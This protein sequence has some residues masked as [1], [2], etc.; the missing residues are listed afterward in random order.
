MVFVFHVKSFPQKFSEPR[1]QP[2]GT[3]VKSA[4]SASAARGLLVWI[5]GADMAALGT[6]CCGRGPTYKVEEDRH[7]C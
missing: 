2:G 4:R 3:V 6:P 7:G 5:P 1:G